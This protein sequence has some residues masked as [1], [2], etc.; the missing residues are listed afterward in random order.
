[1]FLQSEKNVF[2]NQGFGHCQERKRNS[3]LLF[4]APPLMNRTEG[5]NPITASGKFCPTAAHHSLQWDFPSVAPVKP[6]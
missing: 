5:L 4:M 3:P 6:N 1:M 2:R